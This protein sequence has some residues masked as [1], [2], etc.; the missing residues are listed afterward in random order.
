MSESDDP[1]HPLYP[2]FSSEHPQEECFVVYYRGLTGR[3]LATSPF[4]KEE[5]AKWA[6]AQMDCRV[7]IARYVLSMYEEIPLEGRK[8]LRSTP[9]KLNKKIRTKLP[10]IKQPIKVRMP[11]TPVQ[12]QLDL[13]E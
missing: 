1:H 13:E 7:K 4:Y 12:S 5:N 11:R 2:A 6:A 9:P 8:S 3:W 10:K